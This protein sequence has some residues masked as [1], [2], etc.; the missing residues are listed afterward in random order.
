M[1]PTLQH[2]GVGC[3]PWSPLGGGREFADPYLSRPQLTK[4]V[5][6]RPYTEDKNTDRSKELSFGA[7]SAATQAIIAKIEEIAKKRDIPMSHVAFAWSVSKPFVTAPIIG[8]TKM[9]QLKDMIDAVQ[10]EL[11]KEEE[12]SIDKLYEPTKTFGH[13]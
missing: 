9:E 3:I 10:V 7:P 12:E 2:F 11:T 1:M 6:A 13:S 4:S 8:T 5:L